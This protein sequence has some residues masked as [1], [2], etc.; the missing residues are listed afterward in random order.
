MGGVG[1][2]CRG[3]KRKE[4]KGGE[5]KRRGFLTTDWLLADFARLLFKPQPRTHT[6]THAQQHTHTHTHPPH[7]YK[8]NLNHIHR[9]KTSFCLIRPLL[10]GR[11]ERF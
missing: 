2:Y 9:Y 5:R 3:S 4:K 6:H 7:T 11:F 8:T 1:G 10:T